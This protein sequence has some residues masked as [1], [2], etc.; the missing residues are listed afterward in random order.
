M[1]IARPYHYDPPLIPLQK[2]MFKSSIH[3]CSRWGHTL[4]ILEGKCQCVASSHSNICPKENTKKWCVCFGWRR[5]R[6]SNPSHYVYTRIMWGHFPL[7]H[8]WQAQ[9]LW[10]NI[11]YLCPFVCML[12]CR[13]NRCIPAISFSSTR[14]HFCHVL[15]LSL[16]MVITAL[17]ECTLN[18]GLSCSG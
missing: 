15:F 13:E 8:R 18:Y 9:Y 14:N 16:H 17:L 6:P 1:I 3:T 10:Y 4:D 12:E 7:M 2:P 5:V 11:Q